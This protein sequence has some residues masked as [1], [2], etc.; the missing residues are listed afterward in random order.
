MHKIVKEQIRE[1]DVV[2]YSVGYDFNDAGQLEYRLQDFVKLLVN[3]IPEFA[4]GAHEGETTANKDVVSKVSRAAKAIYKIK[5]F[6]EVKEIYAMGNE[7]ADDSV[8]KKY[9][10][11]GEFGEL[12]L[13]YLLKEF[14]NTVPLVSKIYFKDSAG[15]A[16]HGFDAVH[17]NEDTKS[18]WLGESK[19][20]VDGKSGLKELIKDLYD[21]FN[22]SYMEDEFAVIS[23][24]VDLGVKRDEKSQYWLDLLNETTSLRDQLDSI[25]VP[26][27]CTYTCDIY[28][29]ENIDDTSESFL[30]EFEKEI[31]SMKE[32]FD[33]RNTH[34]LKD[35]LKILVILFPVKSKNELV[36]KLHNNLNMMQMIGEL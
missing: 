10:K 17:V 7:I 34:P 16:V 27:I 28:S 15:V 8:E 5:E 35:K 30:G 31:K 25:V 20:Y 9:L 33:A 24:W 26:L 12:I 32:Y 22:T 1:V 36:K 21:H 19:M 3:L 13:F 18:L 4:F 11:R 6:Q 2:A 14:H 23:K 29:K